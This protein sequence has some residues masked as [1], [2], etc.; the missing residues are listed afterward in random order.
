MANFYDWEKHR[1]HNADV[2][3]VIGVSGSGKAYALRKHR[4]KLVVK[5]AKDVSDW[6]KQYLKKLL[7]G[8]GE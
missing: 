5:H 1:E 2:T 6:I 4:I 8:L 3:I 7:E